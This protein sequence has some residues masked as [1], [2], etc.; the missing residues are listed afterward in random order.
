LFPEDFA[1]F[2]G[3]VRLQDILDVVIISLLIYGFLIWLKKTSSRFMLVGI[4]L[5]GIIY[6]LA[7]SFQLY[8][9]AFIL[10]GFFAVLIF[11]LVVIFQEELRRFLERLAILG[12]IR[13]R[14]ATAF[15]REIDIITS[16]V[17]NLARKKIGALMVIMGEE[18][19]ERHIE[20]G[21]Q[22]NGSLS[23][24]L[25]ESI[26]DPNSIGHDGAVII[27][28]G[29]V[30]QFG[31]HL[32]LSSNSKE[33]GNIGL[34]HT[35]ALG[36]AERTDALCIVVS[37]ERGTIS[38]ARGK[39]LNVL[40]NAPALQTMLEAFYSEKAPK[41]QGRPFF[42]W[43][44]ENAMEKVLAVGLASIL[45]IAFGYQRE[46][47]QRDIVVPIEYRNVATDWFIEEPKITEAKVIL[48]G[49]EQ[50][51]QLFV[52]SNLKISLDLSEIKQGGQEIILSK[53]MI[54][55][56]S[57]ISVVGIK[58]DRLHI[59]AFKLVPVKVPIEVRTTGAPPGGVSIE[60]IT[61]AP[62]TVTVLVPPRS[63]RDALYIRTKPIN[64]TDVLG[65]TLIT[66]E[67]VLPPEIRFPG[68]KV[69]P[70]TVAIKV[71]KKK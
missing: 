18:P 31:C 64:L 50:A 17:A 33:F 60:K 26:F 67:F 54:K 39:K 49:P 22:L 37:E 30:V 57:N 9:T 58:P 10:Q 15:G 1:S 4:I 51:F 23:Q 6:A 16:T 13:K 69:P 38:V 11:A 55:T 27:D 43:L 47:V 34:R 14:Y 8:M 42:R 2:L 36:L 46:I 7:R 62:S 71:K 66:P 25:L 41:D 70:V 63:K 21:I 12:R 44:R 53:S 3:A 40:E 20:Q 56:P 29:K 52:P 65:D 61:I 28:E 48:T 32:P 45:W 59:I 24:P 35:A 68:E 19:I 5:L